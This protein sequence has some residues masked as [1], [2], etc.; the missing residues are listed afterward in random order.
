MSQIKGP[1]IFLAQFVGNKPPFNTLENITAWAKSLGYLEVQI[2]APAIQ[3][4][5]LNEAVK[6][7][8]YCD[9]I[10][11]R[12]NGLE[13][14]ELTAHRYGQLVAVHPAYDVLLDSFAPPAFR[15]NPKAR[16]EWAVEQ[17]K[18]TVK[19]SRN[20]GLS[21]VPT[22]SGA[23]LWHYVYPWPP[24]PKGLVELAFQELAKRWKPILD[25]A[26]EN[27]INLA[28]E[29]HPAEDLHDGITFE[30]FLQATGNHKRVSILYDPSHLVL[31]CL[32][33]VGYLTCYKDYIK[34]FH[35]KDAEL[36]PSPKSGVYGGYQEWK[37]RPGRFRSLG[38][39]QIDFKQVFSKLTEIGYDSWAVLEWEC[40]IKEAEQGAREG[41]EFIKSML[42]ETSRRAFD[43]FAK[44]E[45]NQELN[46]R[47]LGLE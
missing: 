21:V 46:E 7:K 33:Y 38:D 6:S 28:Y 41:A 11:G 22:F 26:E 36:R 40:C 24:R 12:C 15:G 17:M 27:G 16:S 47:I 37:D 14:T 45:A 35:A 8:D 3:L 19:A 10:K 34:A 1:A 25:L 43:D 42:I 13:I 9:E 39:G 4:I 5:D 18:K 31:Q 23:L 32:D 44:G 29:I 20:L 2:P 30:R